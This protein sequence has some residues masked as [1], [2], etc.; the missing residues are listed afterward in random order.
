MAKAGPGRLYI[1]NHQSSKLCLQGQ[2]QMIPA[3]S[4]HVKDHT[5]RIAMT[6]VNSFH[7]KN[8]THLLEAEKSCM[9]EEITKQI[10]KRKL[11]CVSTVNSARKNQHKKEPSSQTKM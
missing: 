6:A 3:Y 10:A 2:K 8:E 1:G 4:T 9:D 5:R 7:N 11:F